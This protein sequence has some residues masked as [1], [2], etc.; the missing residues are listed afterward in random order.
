MSS[1]RLFS[2][3]AYFAS[4]P[5]LV[6]AEGEQ[7][8]TEATIEATPSSQQLPVTIESA[9]SYRIPEEV[10][11][12]DLERKLT[13]WFT[14]STLF[15]T[16][17]L[18]THADYREEADDTSIDDTFT[19]QLS[20]QLALSDFASI[21]S[22]V[23]YDSD[24]NRLLTEEVF[25]L[26]ESDPWEL[27]IGKEYTPFGSY[28]SRFVSG[29]MVE[30]GETQADRSVALT[31]GPSDDLDITLMFYQGRA[32][33][34]GD[35]DDEWNWSVGLESWP[36]EGLSIGLSYQADLADAD[37]RLLEAWDDRYSDRVAGASGYLFL[38]MGEYACSLEYL[39]ALSSFREIEADQDQPSAWNA[40]ISR[41][42]AR[43]G[44]EVAL[45]LEGSRELV[46]MPT[47][48]Y[49]VS[50]TKFVNRRASFTIEYLHGV[51]G[52]GAVFQDGED[53]LDQVDLFGAKVSVEL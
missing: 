23:E 16:E 35:S 3:A 40:E 33:T 42:L 14:L 20:L 7:Q 24:E 30:F 25:L 51:F 50:L 53:A 31:Y 48:Q 5:L 47:R 8:L 36:S 52:K 1:K 9:P 21:E 46:D 43:L 32:S 39:T 34:I 13:D 38:V 26:L 18:R 12:A 49:G 4:F 17:V 44:S 28:F 45:R 2:V 22:V 6:W 41:Y 29:P 15:E 11:E 37:D 10:R 19:L 27:S